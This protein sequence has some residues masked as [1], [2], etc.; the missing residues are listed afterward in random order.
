MHIL[1]WPPQRIVALALLI[2]LAGCGRSDPLAYS[3]QQ[4]EL[5]QAQQAAQRAQERA[6]ALEPFQRATQAAWL[7][8]VALVPLAALGI[9]ID[10][11]RQRRSPLVKAE[12]GLIPIPRASL[13]SVR[14]RQSELESAITAALMAFHHTQ[15]LAAQRPAI[16][17]LNLT[18]TAPA[19]SHGTNELLTLPA[20]DVA[21][22]PPSVPT[23]RD[24][25][26]GGTIHRGGKLILGYDAETGQAITGTWLDLMY[27]AVAGAM[28]SGK[29]ST[30]RFFAL[31]AALHGARFIVVDPHLETDPENSLAW[32]LR[33]L[34]PLMLCKPVARPADVLAAA[35]LFRST[36]ERRVHGDADRTP[37]IYLHDEWTACMRD[38]QIAAE[39]A[40]IGEMGATEWRKVGGF[41]LLGGQTWGAERS[42]GTPFRNALA[43]AYC[44]R[45]K[46]PEAMKLLQLGSDTPATH[47]LPT[48]GAWLYRTSGELVRVQMPRCDASDVGHVA[49]LLLPRPQPTTIDIPPALPVAACDVADEAAPEAT[50]ETPLRGH[51]KALDARAARVRALVRAET[52]TRDILREV[53]GITTTGGDKYAKAAA[54][55]RQIISQLV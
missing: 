40:L 34:E 22:A 20:A 21:A 9:G 12:A 3:R 41:G 31:Q 19:R 32:S 1:S 35:R 43:S 52:P 28:R 5:Q 49:E 26:D 29:S 27:A 8:F 17:R 45:I 6:V 54:E 14:F 24:L 53:W 11:Y 55:L 23:F 50:D 39:L 46:R 38:P 30:M 33:P 7:I 4:L 13:E 16:D 42:G 51:Q 25:L 37:V 18:I 47:D 36:M 15:Q 2:L 44:H 48:G 10:A